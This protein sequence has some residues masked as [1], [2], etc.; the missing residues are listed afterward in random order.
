LLLRQIDMGLVV[1]GWAASE[2]QNCN[3]RSRDAALW[4]SHRGTPEMVDNGQRWFTD[5]SG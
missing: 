4:A 2:E 3:K 5:V 1:S